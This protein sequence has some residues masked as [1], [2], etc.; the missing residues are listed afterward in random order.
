MDLC[1][2][3]KIGGEVGK[4]IHSIRIFNIAVVDVIGTIAIAYAIHYYYPT[5]VHPE[6]NFPI[7]LLAAFS[8][9]IICHRL[10]CVRTTVDK[11]LFP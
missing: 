2:F 5:L 3:S 9:G 4:G 11:L 10:F 6:Y 1:K 8:F 7:L